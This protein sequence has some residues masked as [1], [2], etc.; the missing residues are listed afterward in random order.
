VKR[1]WGRYRGGAG[2]ASGKT[3]K[4]QRPGSHG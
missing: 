2:G 1:G 3:Q 4:N